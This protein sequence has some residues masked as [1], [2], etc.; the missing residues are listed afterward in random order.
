M[1][2]RESSLFDAASGLIGQPVRV[3]LQDGSATEGVLYCIDPETD[4]VALL[5]PSG[6]DSGYSVK[7]V[8]AHHARAVE[9]GPQERADIPTLAALKQESSD[10]GVGHDSR[11]DHAS[12][13]RRRDKLGQFLAEVR[14][15]DATLK[16]RNWS[17]L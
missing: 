1:A 6:D 17:L 4:H 8:M 10:Q 14:E 15:L 7:I 5:C 2:A 3:Q 13:A 11:D 12:I 9:K 16:Y